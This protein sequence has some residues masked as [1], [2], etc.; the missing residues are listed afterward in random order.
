MGGARKRVV[1]LGAGFAGVRVARDLA[2]QNRGQF[3]IIL[4]NNSPDHTDITS[5]YEVATAYLSHESQI[6]SERIASSVSVPLE[7]IFAGQ[8]MWIQV[9]QVVRLDVH[10]RLVIF[11]DK[12][13]ISYD[14][15][16]ITLGAALAT[17]GVPGVQEFGFNVKTLADAMSLRHHIVRQFHL[18]LSLSPS[19]KSTALTFVVVGAGAAG[20]ETAA[21]LAGNVRKQCVKHG[22]NPK[23]VRIVMVEAGNR[24]LGAL[25]PHLSDIAAA[26][27][28]A[29]RITLLLNRPVAEITKEGV[30]FADGEGIKSRTIIWTGGLT[31]HPILAAA[32][33]PVARWGV[34][35]DKTLRVKGFP[36]IFI[37]G[38]SAVVS[39][40]P[41]PFPATV[42]V[43]YQE[44]KV[45]AKNIMRH[46]NH[47]P[48]EV[49]T[50]QGAGSLIAIGGK[51]AIA[52]IP[53][54]KGFIGFLP[55]LAKQLVMLRYWSWYLN[56]FQALAF[57]WH[58]FKIQRGN[59]N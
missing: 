11:S 38:D 55:W 39:E 48:L 19:E 26:H 24:I 27:L 8:P 45:V 28:D 58:S 15:L 30:L 9:K 25:P 42:P 53:S 41:S 56:P 23:D 40:L 47:R 17:F 21:E 1:I 51:K 35:C 22:L 6:S 29:Q 52:A 44:A 54:H 37:A 59:D 50:H 12:S 43:A 36:N 20:V 32:G 13:S 33:L 5:L 16:V 18:A 49:Y 2:R 3:E 4:V 14:I 57:R 7:K 10:S 31:I 46:L 34:E